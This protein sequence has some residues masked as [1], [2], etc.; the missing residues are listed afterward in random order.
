MVI[1]IWVYSV[2]LVV[3]TLSGW[4]G[5]FGYDSVLGKC[6]YLPPQHQDHVHPRQLFLS[7]AFMVPLVL[8]GVSY[9]T[10]WRTTLRDCDR[11]EKMINFQNFC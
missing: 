8:I 10:I 6:D 4:Y 11:L 3:P 9:L 7:I 2:V 1:G 5:R